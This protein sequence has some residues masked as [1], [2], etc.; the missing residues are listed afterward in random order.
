M[1]ISGQQGKQD[2][3]HTSVRVREPAAPITAAVN[4]H[5]RN[6]KRC[7]RIHPNIRS[8]DEQRTEE[9]KKQRKIQTRASAEILSDM[10]I[11]E[12]AQRGCTKRGKQAHRYS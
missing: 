12:H 2:I 10:R 1:R 6:Q 5:Q 4:K 7:E 11:T 9:E 8:A 3:K